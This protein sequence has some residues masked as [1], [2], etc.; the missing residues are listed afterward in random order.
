MGL[1]K[2]VATW[3]IKPSIF[4]ITPGAS[5]PFYDAQHAI[6]KA[7]KSSKINASDLEESVV[8]R[9]HAIMVREL[10][11]VPLQKRVDSAHL[12]F[13]LAF[14]YCI[15]YAFSVVFFFSVKTEFFEKIDAPFMRV[16]NDS[17]GFTYYIVFF[18]ITIGILSQVVSSIWRASILKDP[19]NSV[20]FPV[21]FS[22]PKLWLKSLMGN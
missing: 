13:A 8:G 4:N 21:Y 10:L 16:I 17:F 6:K 2:K 22:S 14:L 19:L 20:P 9:K 3:L 11:K 15:I 1:I 7:A 18:F 5:N 12:Q